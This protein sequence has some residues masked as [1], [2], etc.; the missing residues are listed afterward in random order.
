MD[1]VFLGLL[2]LQLTAATARPQSIQVPEGWSSSQ[3]GANITYTPEDL[4][5]GNKFAT[6]EF[7]AESLQ[8]RDLMGWFDQHAQADLR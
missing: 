6:T 2:F 7:P 3:D 8:G 4:P 5:A 1:T